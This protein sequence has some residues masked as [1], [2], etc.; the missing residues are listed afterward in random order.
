MHSKKSDVEEKKKIEIIHNFITDEETI[1]AS[2][3]KRNEN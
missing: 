3:I 2:T 1:N